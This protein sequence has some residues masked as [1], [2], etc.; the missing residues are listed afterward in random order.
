MPPSP[1]QS[2]PVP[3][4]ND[5]TLMKYS[6]LSASGL[7]RPVSHLMTT[8]IRLDSS[9]FHSQKLQSVYH[10]VSCFYLVLFYI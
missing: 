8:V 5:C 1:R 6:E 2:V 4:C 3:A 9:H 7:A 10:Y